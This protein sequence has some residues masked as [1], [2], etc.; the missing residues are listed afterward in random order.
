MTQVP[1]KSKQTKSV[2]NGKEINLT[3]DNMT[4]NS[5]YFKV[6]KL[7]H[8]VC[9]S[10]AIEGN[11]SYINLND[12]FKVNRLG[13]A[14]IID[15]GKYDESTSANLQ[16]R[17][18][19]GDLSSSLFSG[20]IDLNNKGYMIKI[21]AEDYA[22]GTLDVAN[23]TIGLWENSDTN[24]DHAIVLSIDGGPRML[25][26]QTN[27]STQIYENYMYCQD[28]R[29]SSSIEV[30]KDIEKFNNKALPE[31]LNTDVY[32]Y[33]YKTDK[34]N[35]NKKIGVIISDNYNCTDKIISEDK[36]S[37]NLYSMISLSY[38]AIQELQEEIEELKNGK[39]N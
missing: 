21:H 22:Q 33:N 23:G 24:Q 13:N 11:Q 17:N 19:S 20:E 16:I 31:I 15:Q 27:T 25:C 18:N 8:V 32:Y 1:H 29:N 34:E 14:L 30:K 9:Q 37:V 6:D 2:L 39:A 3:S 26:G 5:Q 35:S 28:Y 36:K 12:V 7:G 4:I 10:L 38:K